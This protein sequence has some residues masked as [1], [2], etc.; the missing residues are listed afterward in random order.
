MTL[1]IKQLKEEADT[2]TFIDKNKL[3]KYSLDLAKITSKWN[4]YLLDEKIVYEQSYMK[5]SIAKKKKYEYYIADYHLRVET[6]KE[7]EMYLDADMELLKEK[8][9][10]IISREKINFIEGIIKTLNT[11][12]FNVKN[13]IEWQKF[14]A[15][16]Y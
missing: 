10:M 1:S 15:G 4:R 16:A 2:D 3:D 5:Y 11:S 8:E 9:E 14:Q 12:S 7:K 13:A 6:S